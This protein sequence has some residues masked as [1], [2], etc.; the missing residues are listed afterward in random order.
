MHKVTPG[1]IPWGDEM[2][3]KGLDPKVRGR[4]PACLAFSFGL[5]QPPLRLSLGA[6]PLSSDTGHISKM[7]GCSL[8]RALLPPTCAGGLGTPVKAS[9]GWGGGMVGGRPSCF[10]VGRLTQQV[11]LPGDRWGRGGGLSKAQGLEPLPRG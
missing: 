1:Q 7:N 8:S 3:L 10:P 2:K 5:K 6:P 4:A 9:S 11:D